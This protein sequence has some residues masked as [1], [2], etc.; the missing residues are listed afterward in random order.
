[1]HYSSEVEVMKEL[2]IQSWRNLSKD[3]FFRFL[4]M[5]PEVDTEVALKLVG[6]LPEITSFAKVALDDA[7]RAYEAA[8]ASNERSQEMVHQIHLARLSMLKGELDKDLSPEERMRV[9]DDI[10]DVNSNSILK[11]SENKNF[12]SEQFDKKLGVT[13]AAGATVVTAVVAIMKS[14]GRP[15]G[16]VGRAFRS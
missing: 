4:D 5:V 3:T 15:G 6:Q 14:G 10:R 9:L 16:G 13:L 11:D 1:M 12:L 7:Q 8:L 2:G